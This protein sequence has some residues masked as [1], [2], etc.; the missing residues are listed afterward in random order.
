MQAQ[1]PAAFLAASVR[2]P[3]IV[4]MKRFSFSKTRGSLPDPW[5]LC[6]LSLGVV[7]I[8]ASPAVGLVPG[9]GGIIVFAIGLALVLKN[10][11]WAKR[12]Y[13]AIKRR[14]PKL[15]QLADRGLLRHR[16]KGGGD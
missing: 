6:L 8:L 7:L 3:H 13:V 16:K 14:W 9:P 11:N 15:G 5:R 12:R 10:S 4:S 1:S 2:G